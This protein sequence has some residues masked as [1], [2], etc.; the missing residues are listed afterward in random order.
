MLQANVQEPVPLQVFAADK[1]TDLHARV[2]LYRD[3]ALVNTFTAPHL[4]D[5]IYGT[6]WTPSMEGYFTYSAEF[7]FDEDFTVPAGYFVEPQLVQVTSTKSLLLRLLGLAH[8]NSVVDQQVFNDDGLLVSARIRAYDS[9]ADAQLAGTGGLRFS[10]S[11][12]ATYSEGK[13]S[14][15]KILQES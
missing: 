15:Y 6:T 3:G 7:F 5:G 11:V 13:I 8:E 10:W 4:I 14:S 1:R 12:H 2:Y 9:K